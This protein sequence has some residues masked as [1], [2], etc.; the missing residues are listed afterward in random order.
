MKS[1]NISQILTSADT[2]KTLISL[3][4]PTKKD[5][6]QTS[7]RKWK[8]NILA[9]GSHMTCGPITVKGRSQNKQC[10]D[11]KFCF[12]VGTHCTIQT[13]APAVIWPKRC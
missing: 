12:A 1:S 2:D 10:S 9:S 11:K 7:K 4:I 6:A 13:Q 3:C 8:L 5:H